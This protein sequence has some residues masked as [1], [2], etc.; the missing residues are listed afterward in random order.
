MG[1]PDLVIA[2]APVPTLPQGWSWDDVLHTLVQRGVLHAD[3]AALALS[4]PPARRATFVA[5]RQALREAVRQLP[6]HS[7][8]DESPILRTT[9]GAP[10]LPPAL[11]GSIT[12]KGMLA[13]ATV[14]PRGAGVEHVG[15][16]LERRPVVADL[17]RPSIARK[18][19]TAREF[20]TLD[21]GATDPLAARER[22]LVYFALKEAVY[23]AIDPFVERY[24]R[25]TE[26]EIE[27]RDDADAEV[28]LLLPELV[29][30]PVRVGARW[31]TDNEWIVATAFS[32]SD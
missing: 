4:L 31:S 18:I 3:E 15:L 14:A 24:V 30:G 6:G 1:H 26:V 25:F 23:K 27:L 22:T 28:T 20:S 29:H 9:R 5:G 7:E 21:D 10:L 2:R 8:A 17:T 32:W 19:L 13:M 12:H 16:D 11:T